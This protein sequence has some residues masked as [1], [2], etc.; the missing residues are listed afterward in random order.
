LDVLK[1]WLQKR[2]VTFT[3]RAR[4]FG[5]LREGDSDTGIQGCGK[6]L[7][8]KAVS[9]LW[10]QPLLRFDMGRMFGSL[11]GSLGRKCAPRHCGCRIGGARD[12]LWVEEIDKAFAGAQD[13]RGAVTAGRLRG[14][15]G[16]FP[17]VAF[18]KNRADFCRGYGE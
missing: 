17:D 9:S 8:A 5:L 2:S 10:Q 11:V 4:E 12:S 3:D 18:G 16:D 13:V 7:C 15:S 6:S 1:E 14:Y